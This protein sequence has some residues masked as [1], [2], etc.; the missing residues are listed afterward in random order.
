MVLAAEPLAVP[1]QAE[2]SSYF[3]FICGDRSG[4]RVRDLLFCGGRYRP[5]KTASMPGDMPDKAT[6]EATP[7]P[8]ST[9][10][11]PRSVGTN[12]SSIEEASEELLLC[13]RFL[14]FRGAL[15]ANGAASLCSEDIIFTNPTDEYE[16]REEV[17]CRTH[18]SVHGQ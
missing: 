7:P 13:K 5:A 15:D 1:P 4:M 10:S 11:S 17:S 9:V 12:E 14:T 16:G 2:T 3:S 6:S 18:A 8:S